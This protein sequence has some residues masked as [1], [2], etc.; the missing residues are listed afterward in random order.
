MMTTE[1]VRIL[2]VNPWIHDFAAYDFWARPLG[3]LSLCA[4]LRRAGFA[5]DYFDCLASPSKNSSSPR[6]GRG[7]YT[8]TPIA[9][10]DVFSDVPRTYSRYGVDPE[11]FRAYLESLESPPSLVLVT[12]LM[13]YWYPGAFTAIKIV[14]DA[15]PSVPVVLGGI[16]ATLFP[17]HAGQF[18]GADFVAEGACENEIFA[19]AERFAGAFPDPVPDYSDISSWPLVELSD[20]CF[21]PVL[22]SLGC[23]YRCA[24]CASGFLQPSFRPKSADSIMGEID[25]RVKG[26]VSDFAFYDDALL[27]DADK[28]IG[29]VFDEIIGRGR[30]I[31]IHL[32]NAVHARFI[33]AE[34]A[35][36][37]FRAGVR[38]LRLG[39]E[40]TSS[41]EGL[42]SK[43]TLAEFRRSAE[44]LRK[45]GFDKN[46]LGAYLLCGLPDHDDKEAEES[47]AVVKDCG[48]TP[49]LAHYSPMPRTA[50]W[51]MAKA[52]SRYDIENEP[53]CT[54]NSVFP[55]RPS[56][57][58]EALSRLKR[59]CAA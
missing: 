21:A 4:M 33:T 51:E 59:L 48:V 18:S 16:Y 39:L 44:N 56:F 26:G 23:P 54:N 45:A 47:I 34:L 35:E 55:C 41:R 24:Y 52:C 8:K 29:P 27:V 17:E 46:M 58:W 28:R 10:P 1:T 31:R 43:V 12:C 2:A 20:T 36:K 37:M 49:V 50:L 25:F 14:K 40:T 3:L 30:N 19:I 32:P 11:E 5:V 38:T 15:F 42:D 6:F 7:P 9:K 13:T 57:N 22:G 53:L